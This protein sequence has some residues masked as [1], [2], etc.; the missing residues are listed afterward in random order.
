MLDSSSFQSMLNS[1]PEDIVVLALHHI[2]PIFANESETIYSALHSDASNHQES[3][4]QRE[5]IRSMAVVPLRVGD[6]SVGVLFVNFR[7]PQRFDAP[8]KLFI[9]GLAHYAA[10]GIKN[11]QAFGTLTQR[12]IRELEILQNID[13]ELSRTL[14]LKHVLQA[15]LRQAHD[16]VPSEE[17]SILLTN[18]SSQVLETAAAI[19]RHADTSIM[20][21]ISLQETKGITRWVLEN[22]K[23]VR[24][25]NVH[26]DLPWRDLYIPVAVDVISELDV[27][28]LDGEEV[29][30]V[31]NLESVRESA[32]LQE[33]QDFLLTLAGQAVLAI[34]KAQAYEREK[35]LA[36]EG[37]VL[38]QISKEITSQLDPVHVFDLILEKA[39][40]L[41]HSTTGT[42]WLYDHDRN[43]L[44]IVAER[45]VTKKKKGQ[46]ISLDQ[47]VVGH[48]ASKK[49]L[50]NVNLSQ[51]PW[52]ETYT[53]DTNEMH[54]E[55]AV[56]MLAGSDIRGVLSVDSPSSKKLN[57]RDERLLQG[58]ADLAVIALQNAERYEKAERESQQ[59]QLLYQAGEELGKL[60]DLTQL[61]QP[62]DVI[63][64]IAETHSRGFIVISRYD[65]E[66]QELKLIRTSGSQHSSPHRTKSDDIVNQQVTEEQSTTGIQDTNNPLVVMDIPNLSDSSTHSLIIAPILFKDRYYGNLELKD[67]DLSYFSG[68]DANFY[69]GLA[70]QLAAT[71]YRLETAQARQEFEQR[72][73]SAEEMSSIGQLAFE[74]THRLDNDLGLVESYVIDIQLEL[75]AQA[76]AN[77]VVSKKLDNIVRATRRVLNLSKELKQVLVKSG[78][79][80]AGEPVIMQP[81][82]LL[83]EAQ[84]ILILPSNIQIYMEVE[85]EVANVRVIPSLVADI[86]HNLVVNAIDAMPHGGKIKL[87]A[88]NIARFV[89]LEVID[90]GTGIS[91]Q[92]LSKIFDLF[93]STKGSSGFGLWSARRNAFRNDGDLTV[94]SELGQGTT[95]TLLLPKIEK[96]MPVVK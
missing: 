10:I 35:R 19:G 48:A 2:E 32:F 77:T 21:V 90:T 30:G 91:H 49:Q 88:R 39:L 71:I 64:R 16:Q 53:D 47:G 51:P 85:D 87:R 26:H 4:Q 14:D 60:S 89:A 17:A 15:L 34:K 45:G 82:A 86:L 1:Q 25:N 38:N 46:R 76:V 44:W 81:R 3:F 94:K 93:Y 52:N 50:L 23:P 41:T 31:L 80:I 79:A 33:D 63:L 7:Q 66:T 11:A 58:L 22:K 73:K 40:E 13:R 96:E 5:K 70:Q 9:E 78:E 84:D 43:D 8:Q 36:A 12:R 27:P 42:L 68:T 69:E 57:E 18:S 6:E 29:V 20:Q 24:V 74:V 75:D 95:F 55:L 83:E 61:E 62:Y 65:D 59:F 54:S 72:A 37:L 92:N 28:L 56:P 67:K